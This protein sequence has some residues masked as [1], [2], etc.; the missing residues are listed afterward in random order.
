MRMALPFAF[1][2]NELLEDEASDMVDEVFNSGRKREV[3][4][5]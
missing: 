1:L 2:I 5:W 4:L 3:D